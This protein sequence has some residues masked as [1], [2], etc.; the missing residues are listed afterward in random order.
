MLILR[1]RF[2]N[3]PSMNEQTLQQENEA[4]RGTRGVSENN[5]D[6]GFQPA[7][8]DSDTGRIEVSRLQSGEPATMHIISWLPQEWAAET[9][10]DG[11]VMA[12]KPGIDCGFVS[13]GVFYTRE[14]AAEE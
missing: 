8:R 11:A 3:Q 14:Q 2:R 4:Y 6:R 5:R 9:A 7:F 10:A 13:D 12:L 1:H